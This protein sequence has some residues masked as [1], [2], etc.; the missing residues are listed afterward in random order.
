MITCDN[1]IEAMPKPKQSL[2]GRVLV[3]CLVALLMAAAM[4]TQWASADP[5]PG[6]AD[7]REEVAPLRSLLAQLSAAYPGSVLEVELEREENGRE[8]IWVYEIKLLTDSGRVLKLEYDAVN[9]ELLKIKG[10]SED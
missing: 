8:D 9:L 6:N 3:A 2:P 10:K 7:G 4:N 1:S 5:D